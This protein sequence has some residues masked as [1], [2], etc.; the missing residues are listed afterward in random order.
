MRCNGS[1]RPSTAVTT[2]STIIGATTAPQ[3]C[4]SL[5]WCQAFLVPEATM[6]QRIVWAKRKISR[7]RVPNRVPAES[8]LPGRLKPVLAVV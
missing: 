1:A 5:C 7:A 2:I 8:E 6:A 4:L 3:I